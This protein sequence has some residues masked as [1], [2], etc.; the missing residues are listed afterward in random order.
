MEAVFA[1]ASF[2]R[3]PPPGTENLFPNTSSEVNALLVGPYTSLCERQVAV[4]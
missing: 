2:L 3:Q 1:T 4:A